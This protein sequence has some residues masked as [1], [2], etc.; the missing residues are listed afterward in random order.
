MS[1]SRTNIKVSVLCIIAILSF[2]LVSCEYEEL[3]LF[4][5]LDDQ[6]EIESEENVV[7]EDYIGS[8][9]F[10]LELKE[11]QENKNYLSDINIRKAIFY[12]IDRE[13][14]VQELFGEYNHVLNSLF[15]ESS[16]YYSPSWSEYEYDISKA[17]DFLK[18]A[19]Y[20]INNPLYITIGSRNNNSKYQMIEEMIKEDLDKIGIKIWTFNKPPEEWYPDYVV[21]GNYE[22]G[23]WSI[24]N[25]Y[26]NDLY[27]MFNSNKL[28][29]YETEE[30]KNCLNFYWYSN[31]SIDMIL[32]R[33]I[34]EKD[35]DKK[36]EL[37]KQFQ[38][39]L[40]DDAIILPLYSR[41]FSI[42][43]NKQKIKQINVDIIDNKVF[44]NIENWKLAEDENEI[45]IG[46]EGKDCEPFDLFGSNFIK[47]LL[48][49]DLWKIDEKGEYVPVLVEES[50]TGS[51]DGVGASVRV[52]LKDNIFWENGD[53][54]TSEDIEYTY[55][56]ILKDEGITSI[57]EDYARIEDI[58]VI[59]EKEFN[60]VF[61][62]YF[63]GWEKLFSIVLPAGSL[64]DVD[65][66]N[67]NIEDVMASGC[68]KISEYSCGEYLLMEK[69]E[70]YYGEPP[71]V[72]KIMFL[73]DT[74]INNL[75]GMLRE[76]EIDLLNV[77]FDLELIT[78][79]EENEDIGLL[80][81]P[82]DL[83]EHL[84]ISLK[85]VEV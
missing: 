63:K 55:D 21:K 81:K 33:L 61:N 83:M 68:Y 19:G 71:A 47:S 14:I 17:K 40:A 4:G 16:Y 7:E 60:I 85:P 58:E 38:D 11:K 3:D 69:N 70:F 64:E 39:V 75:I 5:S 13:E 30:N 84:A 41:L 18:N 42:A 76:G 67:F 82:G 57:D 29:S 44:Y 65:I 56:T 73:Y 32:D 35:E 2:L 50:S 10:F 45:I 74:D 12:A 31:S 1:K 52:L 6:E 22:L 78:N 36:K 77:P 9:E 34:E 26:G 23:L 72:E 80:I 15:V 66:Y 59:S 51:F 53:A 20:G 79:L 37:L 24:E 28:P 54:I 62:E 43:Y 46:C 8:E 27:S 48:M 49:A 25:Y